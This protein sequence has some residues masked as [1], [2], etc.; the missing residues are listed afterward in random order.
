MG[1]VSLPEGSPTLF[2]PRVRE[3]TPKQGLDYPSTVSKECYI[4]SDNRCISAWANLFQCKIAESSGGIPSPNISSH[5]KVQYVFLCS[6]VGWTHDTLP[7]ISQQT[8]ATQWCVPLNQL[9]KLNATNLQMAILL[10]SIIQCC[11]V[12]PHDFHL[13]SSLNEFFPT[14]KTVISPHLCDLYRIQGKK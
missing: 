7:R 3:Q 10:L 14:K 4:P 1:Y 9:L 13:A 6:K 8:N 2:F 11:M 5:I 12:I